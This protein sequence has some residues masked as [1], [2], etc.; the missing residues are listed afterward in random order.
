M[1]NPSFDDMEELTITFICAFSDLLEKK[2]AHNDIKL[3]N[4]LVK[5]E[6]GENIFMV[7]DF[8]IAQVDP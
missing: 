7:N 8:S 6:D 5:Q 2:L 1:E 3:S 4:V